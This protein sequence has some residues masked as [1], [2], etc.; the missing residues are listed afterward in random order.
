MTQPYS[1]KS[2]AVAGKTGTSVVL[3]NLAVAMFAA[4]TARIAERITKRRRGKKNEFDERVTEALGA[5]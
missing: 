2:P 3:V 5:D 1:L 4:A